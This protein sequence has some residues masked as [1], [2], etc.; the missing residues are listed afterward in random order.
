MFENK[1]KIAQFM[2]Y[3]L[4]GNKKTKTKI[5]AKANL[6]AVKELSLANRSNAVVDTSNKKLAS[7]DDVVL[8]FSV[9]LY[10]YVCNWVCFAYSTH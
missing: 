8:C 1:N 4:A 7:T 3:I 9:P 2:A 10:Y 6:D 5:V